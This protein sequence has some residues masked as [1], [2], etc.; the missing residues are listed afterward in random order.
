MAG[1][2]VDRHFD[3]LRKQREGELN[4]QQQE[5]N[6]GFERQAARQ[7]MSG[8]GAFMKLRAQQEENFG[9]RRGDTIDDVEGQ[10]ALALGE[11]EARDKAMAFNKEQAQLDRDQRQL[12]RD[13][14]SKEAASQRAFQSSEAKAERGFNKQLFDKEMQFKN[15]TLNI[16]N[17]QFAKQMQMAMKQFKLDEKVSNFNMDMATKQWNK[18]EMTDAFAE[19]W[20]YDTDT[21]EKS[22]GAGAIFDATR[23]GGGG[24]SGNSGFG[25]LF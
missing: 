3:Y 22:G 14:T 6:E 12:D 25:G 13:F 17:S 5:A 23:G 8:S 10:R 9:E 15:K 18:K 16:Q 7:G 20:G 19:F 4:R 2:V 1:S 24:G 21:G 11:I